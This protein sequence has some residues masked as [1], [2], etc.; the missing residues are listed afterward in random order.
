MEQFPNA[1]F[2]PLRFCAISYHITISQ[3][4]NNWVL[5]LTNPKDIII[6]VALTH[7]PRDITI[8]PLAFH[9]FP[10]DMVDPHY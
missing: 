1:R 8:A 9:L 5:P 2:N 10:I 7:G 6:R 3:K 4:K